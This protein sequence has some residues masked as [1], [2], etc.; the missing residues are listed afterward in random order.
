MLCIIHK[1]S[2]QRFRKYTFF[3]RWGRQRFRCIQCSLYK[4]L[5]NKSTP[6][7]QDSCYYYSS[8]SPLR[9]HLSPHPF[10]YFTLLIFFFFWSSVICRS[11]CNVKILLVHPDIA[12]NICNNLTLAAKSNL[13]TTTL[14]CKN[15]MWKHMH[16]LLRVWCMGRV[17]KDW[18]VRELR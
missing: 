5:P 4:K 8:I 12:F 16:R 15:V 1:K 7:C 14:I 18:P 10:T 3:N 11:A 17:L 2:L 13:E 6:K 9:V